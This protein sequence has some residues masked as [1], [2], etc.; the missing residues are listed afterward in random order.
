VKTIVIALLAVFALLPP[1]QHALSQEGTGT[2]GIFDPETSELK[3]YSIVSVAGLKAEE[4]LK[5]EPIRKSI[6]NI[7]PL[8]EIATEKQSVRR[9]TSN[10]PNL[11]W[12]DTM[13]RHFCDSE[14]AVYDQASFAC[15]VPNY[16]Y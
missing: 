5:F 13:M 9:P 8:A 11:A 12:L 1:A 3:I 7:Y 10:D 6:L 15:V 14:M 2:I 4:V 16:R